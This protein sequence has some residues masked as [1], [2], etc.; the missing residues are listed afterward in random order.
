MTQKLYVTKSDK[1]CNIYQQ[2][3]YNNVQ[4]YMP[5]LTVNAKAI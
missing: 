4:L 5:M 2:L 1:L 3:C